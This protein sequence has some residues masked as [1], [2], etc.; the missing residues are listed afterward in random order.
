MAIPSHLH[1]TVNQ[2]DGSVGLATRSDAEPARGSAPA[3]AP[4]APPTPTPSLRSRTNTALAGL[5]ER[6]AQRTPT[7]ATLLR[8]VGNAMTVGG[9]GLAVHGF[10]SAFGMAPMLANPVTDGMTRDEA[11]AAVTTAALFMGMGEIIVGSSIAVAGSLIGASADELA[12]H[13][14]IVPDSPTGSISSMSSVS[15]S[16]GSTPR[17]QEIEMLEITHQLPAALPGDEMV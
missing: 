17:R 9:S 14:G 13:S 5:Q 6:V 16:P 8:G 15:P 10:A 2:P 3:S 12:Q 1:V 4:P 7:R 11:H